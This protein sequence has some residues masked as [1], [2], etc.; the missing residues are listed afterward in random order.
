[1]PSP[2]GSQDLDAPY[3][4]APDPAD[5]R[6]LRA[7]DWLQ[8]AVIVGLLGSGFYVGFEGRYLWSAL[9]IVAGTTFGLAFVL[10]RMIGDEYDRF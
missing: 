8:I 6:R 5:A 9:L 4:G 2:P 3:G 10:R 1:M 7:P